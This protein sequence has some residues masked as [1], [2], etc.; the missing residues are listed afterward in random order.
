[1][2][3]L[4]AFLSIVLPV[5]LAAAPSAI[6]PA[7]QAGAAWMR[8][9]EGFV[10]EAARG[11]ID[12]LFLGDSIT[13]FWRDPARGRAIWDREYALLKA[14]NFGISGDRTQ[15][16]LWRIENGELIGISPG[17]I[18]LMI[19]TNNLGLE[20]DLV[21][22][23]NTVAEAVEG[24]RKV[25]Q[26]L[27]SRLPDARILLLGVLPRADPK[28]PPAR[29]I[30]ELNEALSQMT[31]D[32]VTYHYFGA[33]FLRADG[34]VVPALMPD[35]LHPNAQGYEVF[36]ESIREPLRRLFPQPTR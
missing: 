35:L 36:A 6:E 32:S 11:G 16:L 8:R 13:D 20:S 27:Q 9:H 18:V 3:R 25:L 33:R 26:A 22:P 10:A 5:C 17:V 29:E 1:M 15:H 7:P 34:S 28:G 4:I 31:T 2:S 12:V 19:G 14:A 24:V 23:R 21:T 30:D